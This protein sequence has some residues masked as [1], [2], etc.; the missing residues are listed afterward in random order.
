[1]IAWLL[2]IPARILVALVRLYQ[3]TLS[4]LVPVLTVGTCACRF[5]PTCSHYAI[6]ALRTH[7]AARGSWLALRRLVRCTPLHPGGVDPV[8]APRPRCGRVA[9]TRSIQTTAAA[10]GIMAESNPFRVPRATFPTFRNG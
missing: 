1:M 2:Q 6:E 5:A 8:P 10:H 3:R 9:S 4:P 7:G